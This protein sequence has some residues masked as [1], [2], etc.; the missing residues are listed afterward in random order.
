M[1]T[2]ASSRPSPYTLEALESRRLLAAGSPT[3]TFLQYLKGTGET[4]SFAI[5]YAGPAPIDR[6]TLGDGDVRVTGPNEFAA[7]A[8]FLGAAKY[9]P[10]TGTLARYRVSGITGGA[11]ELEVG[12]EEVA[13]VNEDL[14]E[15]AVVGGFRIGSKGRAFPRGPAQSSSLTPSVQVMGTTVG[16][17][18]TPPNVQTDFGTIVD[19]VNF[20]G[21]A[22][23]LL[24]QGGVSIQ[25]LG[26]SPQSPSTPA[27]LQTS[28][29]AIEIDSA[30][31]N[32]LDVD[33]VAGHPIFGTEVYNQSNTELTLK[34]SG[35]DPAKRYRF[36]FMHGDT[37]TSLGYQSTPQ[38]YQIDN[39]MADVAPL[40][41]NN[42]PGNS[43]AI[44]AVVVQGTT[45]LTYRMPQGVTR[46]PSFSGM[47]IEE[48]TAGG[49]TPQPTPGPG[50]LPAAAKFLRSSVRLTGSS[51]TFD[52]AYGN[53]DGVDL[54][55]VKRQPVYV[56]GPAGYAALA[57]LVNVSG[58]L[59]GGGRIAT[60]RLDW[61]DVTSRY[62]ISLNEGPPAAHVTL[63]HLRPMGW[64]ELVTSR[65]RK[66]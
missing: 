31:G 3:A 54:E 58:R 17:G 23:N 35:L 49:T 39:G 50:P 36:Q 4:R 18:T 34:V 64:D 66:R 43:Y 26:R 11:Y 2:H 6:A 16:S 40:S 60:Y 13:D 1:T 53:P 59:P 45:S 63:F 52:I 20:G 47:V 10:G 19:A 22:I 61:M 37:R 12:G 25:F 29:F 5:L 48:A 21:T 38:T 57:T 32:D 7:D 33:T 51:Q 30:G 41:F 55:M 28:P 56:H 62:A 46:G 42:S 15:G 9:R 24:G 14:V 8:T 65:K 27:V 44:T